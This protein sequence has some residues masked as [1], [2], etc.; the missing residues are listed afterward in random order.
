[1]ADFPVFV[2]SE[3]TSSERRI[4]PQWSI[5]TFKTKMWPITGIPPD[6]QRLSI[7]YISEDDC[8]GAFNIE[9]LSVIK[10][11]DRRPPG[12]RPN[13]TD[14]S[15][16]DKFELTEQEYDTRS[17]SLRAFKRRNQ[18]GR[19]DPDAASK[20]EMTLSDVKSRGVV[21][22][23]RCKV[24]GESDRRGVIRFVGP[25]SQIPGGGLWV[26]VE[27]DE[28][29]GKNDGSVKGAR[30]FETK[31]KFGG[32]LRPNM[33]HVGNFPVKNFD[34]DLISSDDEI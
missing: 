33:I 14:D 21:V 15:H 2:D 7:P 12:Q 6:S 19:F 31:E 27:Y 18:L 3:D 1:M 5:A 22:G 34:D 13:Y 8:I 10:I 20:E 26:G 16:V 30:Y 28:P 4:S 17:D 23:A 11:T 32:F 24:D 29:V 25:I 9:P